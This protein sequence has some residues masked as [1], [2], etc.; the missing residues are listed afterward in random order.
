MVKRLHACLGLTSVRDLA[1][2]RMTNMTMIALGAMD[3]PGSVSQLIQAKH[4]IT[5][6]TLH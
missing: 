2:E 5:W 1:F 3:Q 6:R 4:L